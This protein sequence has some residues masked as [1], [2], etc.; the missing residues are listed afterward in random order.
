MHTYA[1]PPGR[2]P[3][4]ALEQMSEEEY[5]S[6]VRGKMWEKS[7]GYIVE[8]RARREAERKERERE[9][10][11][12]RRE[13]PKWSERVEEGLRRRGKEKRARRWTGV[14]EGYLR[15]WDDLRNEAGSD[16]GK[17]KPKAL[18]DRIEWPVESGLYKDVGK[19]AVETFLRNA[20]Q[21]GRAGEGVDLLAVLKAERVRWH[22]DKIQQR[23]GGLGLDE[24]TMKAVTAV[25]QVI[26]RMWSDAREKQRD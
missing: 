7:H 2:G 11:R 12:V 3:T 17:K 18:R 15:G 26:D 22:P 16:D 23:F 9:R 20:P 13:Q 5:V 1:P 21:P 8:E 10:E 25:F 24:E 6:Y 4:G 14:W 19:E